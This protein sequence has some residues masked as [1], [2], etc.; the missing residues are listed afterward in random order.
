MEKR[1]DTVVTDYRTWNKASF[2]S[3]K[4]N[5]YSLGSQTLGEL[6]QSRQM[7]QGDIDGYDTTPGYDVS[8]LPKLEQDITRFCRESLDHGPGFFL[9]DRLSEFSGVEQ[10]NIYLV[11]ASVL[12]NLLVQNKQGERIVEVK[13][14]GA[15]MQGGGRY[16]QT[17]QGG[18][19]H[20]D[21]PYTSEIPDYLGLLCIHPS[22][23]GGLSRLISAH[24]IHN[25]LL[26]LHP[27]ILKVLYQPFHFDKRGGEFIPGED[28]TTFEPI[29]KFD[30][31]NIN[32]TTFK[33][34]WNN[35]KYLAARQLNTKNFKPDPKLGLVCA[36]CYKNQAQI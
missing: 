16:H 4:D 12:G 21:S 29:F 31:G 32:D 17:K 6:R 35:E 3:L 20:T 10:K 25:R 36:T 23:E 2:G 28:S 26:Q 27:Q 15:T 14:K 11:I 34:I 9:I 18:S 24:T 19:L 8:M 33:E 1:L 7:F 13:D 5:T 30:F 22:K